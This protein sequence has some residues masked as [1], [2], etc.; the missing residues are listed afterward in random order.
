MEEFVSLKQLAMELGLDRSNTRKY[1]LKSGIRPHKRR[2]PDS[3]GQLTLA[4]TVEEATRIRVK[5]RE[6]GFLGSIRPV[7]KETGFFYVI[8]LVPEL[9]P[10]RIKLGFAED[11]ATRL[12]QHKTAAPTAVLVKCWPC[13]RSWEGTV[14][15]CLAGSGCRLILNEVFECED[16]EALVA[17]GD[18]F[19]GLLPA[20][21]QRSPL[22]EHSP[23]N[24]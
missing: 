13:K 11:M 7:S 5:R 1:V 18:H 20:P 15:D 16:V 24:T 10:H 2:T 21:E 6:E 19:F 4:L 3:G 9:D 23:H 17:K 12:A 14:I 8:R 22:S